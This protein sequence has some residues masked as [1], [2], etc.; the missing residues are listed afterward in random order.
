MKWER[1]AGRNEAEP[2]A[3]GSHAHFILIAEGG[4]CP[5]P[6]Q[7]SPFFFFFCQFES[8]QLSKNVI[9]MHKPVQP[10]DFDRQVA[11]EVSLSITYKDGDFQLFGITLS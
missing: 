6:S 2:W 9:R 11:N 7:F 4:H 3:T 5:K 8:L 10:C 1:P